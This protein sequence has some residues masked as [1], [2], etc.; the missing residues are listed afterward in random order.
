MSLRTPL[1]KAK[2]LGSAKEGSSH[3]WLQRL[4]AIALIPL[5]IWLVFSVAMLGST[6]YETMVAWLQSP[7]VVILLILFI[8]ATFYHTQ[9]GLQVIVEDYVGGWIKIVTLVLINF[10]CIFLAVAGIIALLKVFL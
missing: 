3:W 9:L 4:T 6:S 5:S 7:I 1:S 2:G 10:L 8:V